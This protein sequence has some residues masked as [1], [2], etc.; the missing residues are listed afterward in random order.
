MG[1]KLVVVT[2]MS[3]AGK[4]TALKFLEDIG[5]YCV[6]NLPPALIPKFAEICLRTGADLDKIALGIDIRGGRL[7]DDLIPAIDAIS[8]ED[9]CECSVLYLDSDDETLLK[10]YK[11][12]RRTHPLVKSEPLLDGIREERRLTE[13]IKKR[14]TYILDTSK[15]LSNDLKSA[16]NGIFLLGKEFNSLIINIISFGFKY[17]LPMDADLVFDVRFIPNPFYVPELKALT[18]KDT[19]VRDFVMSFDVSKGF[20]DMTA[21][22]IEFLLPHYITEGKNRLIIAVGCTGGRHRSVTFA[23][24]IY[25]YLN[26]RGHNV[27]LSHRDVTL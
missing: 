19:P 13:E 5:F 1:L 26:G 10:R 17:G 14:A 4:T 6:D 22:M 16:V 11:E 20:L 23:G 24:E 2:G 3:G 21:S 8:G 9:D 15:F 27:Y 12:T 7:F 18:G 25:S